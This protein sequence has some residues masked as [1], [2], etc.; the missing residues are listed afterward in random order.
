MKV[1]SFRLKLESELDLF[2]SAK[3][4]IG[5]IIKLLRG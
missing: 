1:S 2:F 3:T 4:Q 5:R